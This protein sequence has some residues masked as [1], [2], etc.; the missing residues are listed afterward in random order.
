MSTKVQLPTYLLKLKVRSEVAERTLEIRFERPAGMTFKAGQYM[1]LTLNTPPE[2]DDEGNTRSF[3]INSSP[4]DPELIFTT[5]LRDSAFK[6]VLRAMPLGTEVTLDGPF[7]DFTLH[8][9]PARTAVLLAGGIGI[10]PFR[11][12]VRRSAHEHLP[13]RILLFYANR[14]PEDAPFLDEFRGLEHENPHFTFVPTVTQIKAS[15]LPWAGEVGRISQELIGKYLKSDPPSEHRLVGPMYYIAGPP[16]MVL[17]LR[18]ILN[19]AGVNDDDIRTE[20][21]L[22]Y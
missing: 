19:Q 21:F 12:I 15:R 10:T 9:N 6:R 3:S 8:N 20:E 16:G 7:G 11:S 17:G 4:D 18:T 2:T 5:R 13:H 14:R 22:G 1:D